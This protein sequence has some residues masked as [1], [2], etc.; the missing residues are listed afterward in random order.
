MC[1]KVPHLLYTSIAR[2]P[3]LRMPQTGMQPV[4]IP[5]ALNYFE[6]VVVMHTE[7]ARGIVTRQK[8]VP[9][10]LPTPEDSGQKSK[11]KKCSLAPSQHSASQS[12]RTIP[13]ED[14][15]EF[16]KDMP[17]LGEQE[18]K[19]PD[20]II[21]PCV[22]KASVCAICSLLN[23]AHQFLHRILWSNGWSFGMGTSFCY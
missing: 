10:V 21:E 11:S 19:V 8:V 15:T 5:N 23:R 12:T 7:T 14:T 22:P 16:V 1:Y 3:F 4:D 6:E 2:H 20:P 13:T 17:F 18:Y 9:V